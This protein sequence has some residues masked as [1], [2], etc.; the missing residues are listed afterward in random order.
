MNQLGGTLDDIGKPGGSRMRPVTTNVSDGCKRRRRR[1]MF[2]DD[3]DDDHNDA[4]EK[5][6][7]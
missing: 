4:D 2:S 3:D 1:V 6:F 7:L 5:D